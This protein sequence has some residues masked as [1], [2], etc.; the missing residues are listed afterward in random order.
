MDLDFA[1]VGAGL[2][3]LSLAWDLVHEFPKLNLEIFEK[4]R[5]CGGRMAT[6]RIENLRFDHGAPCIKKTEVSARWIDLWKQNSALLSFPEDEQ[7]SFCGKLGMTD[8]AKVLARSL[9]VFYQEK[10]LSLAYKK[11][12]W[13]LKNDQAIVRKAQQV[14]LTCP[15]AQSLEILKMSE[16]DFDPGLDIEYSRALVLLVEATQ[17]GKPWVYREQVG[18]GI[19]SICA[20][21]AK[22]YSQRPSWTVVMDPHWSRDHFD[23]EDHEI[24]AQASEVMVRQMPEFTCLQIKKWKY[25]QPLRI[26]PRWFESPARNLYLAGDAF[27]GP[28]LSGA[29]RSSQ[30]L[31]QN[32]LKS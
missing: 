21:H 26:W 12:T 1:I 29:L 22:G 9:P 3:G 7:N 27:G 6:R 18:G 5:G 10:I 20:Q 25:C 17:D 8:L 2:T 23:L 4:S 13:Y 31:F 15:I 19:F 32:L 24:Q 30:G 14:V 28:S 16:I 11:G